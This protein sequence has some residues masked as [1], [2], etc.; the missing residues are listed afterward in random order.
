MNTIIIG[1]ACFAIGF[2]LGVLFRAFIN[3]YT[4]R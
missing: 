3:D 1:I 4:G 2:F